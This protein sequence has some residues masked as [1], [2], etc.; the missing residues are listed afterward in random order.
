MTSKHMTLRHKNDVLDMFSRGYR[1][2]GSF[3]NVFTSM[4]SM[5]VPTKVHFKLLQLCTVRIGIGY[6]KD[7]TR[8]VIS[9]E[10]YRTSLRRV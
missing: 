3:E 2:V 8:V 4:M 10:I 9:Y 7:L 6:I 1:S 5:P